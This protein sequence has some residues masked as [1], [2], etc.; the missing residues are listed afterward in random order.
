MGYSKLKILFCL[1]VSLLFLFAPLLIGV[2]PDGKVYAMGSFGKK[3]GDDGYNSSGYTYGGYKFEGDRDGCKPHA[4]PEPATW[5]LFG[6]GAAV[7]A[8]FIKKFRAK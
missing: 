7:T 1:A 4:L 3:A 2:I 6:A 8:A 5:L